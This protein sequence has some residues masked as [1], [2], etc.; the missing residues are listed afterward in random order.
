MAN[1]FQDITSGLAELKN[2]YQGPIKDQF[3]E[4]VAIYR[5]AE[6]MK[7]GWSGYQVVRP[8]RVRR[9]QG[10]GATADG[11]TL[12]SIGRQVPVQATISA[13]FNYLRF[14]V[15]GPMIKASASDV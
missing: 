2:Y 7:Q 4:D 10:I 6:K 13:K 9:N 12:P 14:G 5:G 8:L 11:G 1:R 15:T 3:N